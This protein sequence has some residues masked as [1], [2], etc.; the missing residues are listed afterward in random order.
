MPHA[1]YDWLNSRPAGDM[2]AVI[3]WPHS[4]ETIGMPEH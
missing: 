4:T 1:G 3:G 2:P